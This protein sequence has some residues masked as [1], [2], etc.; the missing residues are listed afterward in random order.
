MNDA[1]NKVLPRALTTYDIF[2]FMAVALMVVDHIGYYFFPE[3]LWWR[4]AGR[5]C[6]PVWLF[7]VGYARSRDMG[8]AM[9]AGMVLLVVAN[10]ASGMYVF[11]L[12]ILATV[13]AVR[14]VM[15]P[16]MDRALVSRKTFWAMN[17]VLF[18]VALPTMMVTEYG[19]L[20]LILAIF[21]YIA[22]RVHDGDGRV[23]RNLQ[24]NYMIFAVLSFVG[25]QSVA[26]GF[27]QIQA[28]ALAVGIM[29]ISFLL[30][31][32]RP[33]TVKGTEQGA[34]HL[35]SLPVQ[36]IGRHTLFFYVAHLL[37]FKALGMA[38]LPETFKFMNW[39]W[40]IG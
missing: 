35:L 8:P 3:E 28:L 19:T 13:L 16:L 9:W 23:D 2:K 27:E 21:G 38:L 31:L 32:F 25:Y 5:L 33:A 34:G 37:V 40:F 30:L 6:V 29:V 36:L 11:P 10:V 14:L 18:A 39:S 12:N 1:I 15:D 24:T 20:A 4:V 17:A 26:F 7:L 22:R